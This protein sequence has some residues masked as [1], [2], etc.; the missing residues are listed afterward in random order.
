[1]IDITR[2][3]LIISM[4][5]GH[6]NIDP[7]LRKIIFS[8]HMISFVFLSGYCY[9]KPKNLLKTILHMC[10]TMLL[11]Y[12]LCFLIEILV[13][14]KQ[15]NFE[16]FFSVFKCYIWGYSFTSKF[17][18]NT[19]SVGPV[20]FILLLF[21]TRMIFILIDYFCTT[22]RM[23][24][25]FVVCIS[26]VGVHLGKMG[27]WLPWSFD[28]ACYALIFYALGVVGKKYDVLS[29]V[30]NNDILYFVLSPVWAYMIYAGSMEI[31]IRNYGQYG[32]VIIGSICGFLIINK[33]SC[34][35]SEHLILSK[36]I[37]RLAGQFSMFILIV[38]KLFSFDIISLL[39]KIGLMEGNL[40]N[41]IAT[42]GV[43]IFAGILLG[44][45]YMMLNVSARLR[46]TGLAD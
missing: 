15:F 19:P 38:H 13:N 37:L 20:Y 43:Q 36:A 10:R 41:M 17:H 11:P 5:I 33:L 44:F 6:F 46:R 27:Y 28:V 21:C 31:A 14:L 45:F 26:L 35:I 24:V 42:V 9:K 2:G 1:M 32:L 23:K 40:W 16:Y 29:Y 39:D 34:Y 4:I 3:I 12:L 25:F 22:T 7:L 30:Q 8:C 18:S